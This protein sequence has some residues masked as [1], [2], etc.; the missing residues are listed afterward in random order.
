[1]RISRISLISIILLSCLVISAQDTIVPPTAKVRLINEQGTPVI[2]LGDTLF[3]IR[4]SYGAFT[5]EERAKS[6]MARLQEVIREQE[7]YPDSLKAFSVD[8]EYYVV[9][10]NRILAVIHQ[11]DTIGTGLSADALSHKLISM[12]NDHL[13]SKSMKFNFMATLKNIGYTLVVVIVLILIIWIL[14]WMFR[15]IFRYA[16]V[17]KD[18][19]FKSIKINTYE[20]LS[21]EREYEVAKSLLKIFKIGLIIFLFLIAL[22][23]IF[24][25][26]HLF[27]FGCIMRPGSDHL[28]GVPIAHLALVRAQGVDFDFDRIA[29]VD[30][31]FAVRP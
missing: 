17:H 4:S 7:Y 5:A 15:K 29:D 9:Y 14:N 27:T 1:M 18:R 16:E 21:A 24:S 10:R 22:P 26:F 23:V 11:N 6:L 20:F 28:R 8:D 13:A 25:I 3:L 12:L 2:L 31:H 30:I 19:L